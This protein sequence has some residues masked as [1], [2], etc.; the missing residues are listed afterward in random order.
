MTDFTTRDRILVSMPNV[1]KEQMVVSMHIQILVSC[2]KFKIK[3]FKLNCI[4]C[5]FFPS[6]TIKAY[7]KSI[8]KTTVYIFAILLCD[9]ISYTLHFIQQL[10]FFSIFHYFFSFCGNG[11]LQS[12]THTHT[13][14]HI[15]QPFNQSI[16]NNTSIGLN[17]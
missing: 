10:I 16:S 14:T 11:L 3:F 12:Q 13:Y 6:S 4:F 2:R 15:T 7:F 5:F 17:K 1:S 8:Y 9:H